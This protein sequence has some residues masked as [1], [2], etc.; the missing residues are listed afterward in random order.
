[1]PGWTNT[2]ILLLHTWP[3]KT[4]IS[5]LHYYTDNVTTLKVKVGAIGEKKSILESTKSEHKE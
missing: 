1:M 2:T 3:Y 5:L 4:T